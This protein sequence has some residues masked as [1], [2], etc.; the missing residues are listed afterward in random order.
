MREHEQEE[1][2]Q[3]LQSMVMSN[4][5]SKQETPKQSHRPISAMR[6]FNNDGT[7]GQSS[8]MAEEQ[9]QKKIAGISAQLASYIQANRV[10]DPSLLEINNQLQSLSPT[11]EEQ[12]S[13][14]P[15]V[16]SHEKKVR[17]KI[18]QLVQ[19]EAVFNRNASPKIKQVN[20]SRH[21]SQANHKELSALKPESNSQMLE[22]L[23]CQTSENIQLNCL[24]NLS[25]PITIDSLQY[26]N[27]RSQL[28]E[29]RV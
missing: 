4:N 2:S 24:S 22:Q 14:S 21:N 1:V 11:H 29:A 7:C 13:A 12:K 5:V 3:Q 23:P 9:L 16:L 17:K 10:S 28:H 26:E 19:S 18:N 8:K 6:A 25:I 15:L 20:V 27:I